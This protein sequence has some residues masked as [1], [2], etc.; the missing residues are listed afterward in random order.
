MRMKPF[1]ALFLPLALSGSVR[2]QTAGPCTFIQGV[3]VVDGTGA[4]ARAASV[5]VCGERIAAIGA[6]RPQAGDRIV[7]GKGLALAPGFIDTHSHHAEGTVKDRTILAAISQGIT[8]VVIGQDGESGFP[9]GAF[10]TSLE[11]APLAVNVASY[12][13]HGTLRERV[14][15][16]DYKRP[17]T[18][19]EIIAMRALLRR[20]LASGALGLSTGLEYDPGIY[21]TTEELIALAQEA[22]RAGGR[23]ISHIRSEDRSLF[24]AV[25]EVIRI[26]REARLPVQ[27]SH[28]KLAMKSLWGQA[29]KL[30]AKLDAARAGG[31]DVT[32]DVYPYPYWQ[33]TMTVL[34]PE[35]NFTDRATA[36]FALTELTT[37]E[38]MIVSKYDPEPAYAGKTLAEIARLRGTDPVTTYIDLIAK[39]QSAGGDNESIIATS[40][41]E[42]DIAA[43]TAWPHTN[44]CSDGQNDGR[45]PRG[46]GAF[47]RVLR[48]YVRETHSLSLETAIEKM[49]RLAAAHVGL[50]GR[51]VLQEGA[52][53]DLVLFDPATVADRATPQEPHL[54]A[55]GIAGVW[56]NGVRVL[57]QGKATGALPGR[58]LRR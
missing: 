9:L 14:M 24:Q 25:D 56:V 8:T 33:S 53:A 19:D 48:R 49:T 37:P 12:A 47:P 31:V 32:A 6:V 44:V 57:D 29:D 4:P 46:Y 36:T 51:G 58:V 52:Y 15:G 50:R 17:A 41:D 54:P 28:I 16:L 40:M 45:H 7:E 5:R 55:A 1:L 34:F 22:S 21:S 39:S 26:G 38:G 20:E 27:I 30:L 13:G 43:L 3:Q 10:F 18:E 35:R 2:A 11:A 23:Y 42:R